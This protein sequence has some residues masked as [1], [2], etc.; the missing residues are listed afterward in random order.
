MAL[1]AHYRASENAFFCATVGM[2]KYR[3]DEWT[4]AEEWLQKAIK[5]R[6]DKGVGAELFFLA[7]AQWQQAA[8]SDETAEQH[9]Q[10]A[11]V[12][13]QKQRPHNLELLQIRD[14]ASQLRDQMQAGSAEN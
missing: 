9:F 6:E 13:T 7:M 8:G 14:E 3:G 5:L 4:A 2:A 10:E 1:R 12:W 11:V